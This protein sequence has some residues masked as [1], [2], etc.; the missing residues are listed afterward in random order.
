MLSTSKQS[1]VRN[2]TFRLYDLLLDG[3]NG[4][5]PALPTHPGKSMPGTAAQHQ[6]LTDHLE[7]CL[8]CP[9]HLACSHTLDQETPAQMAASQQLMH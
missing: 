5:S 9:L 7:I 6:D 4:S 8:L 2:F 3:L 1:L